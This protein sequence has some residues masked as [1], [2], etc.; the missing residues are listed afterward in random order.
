MTKRGVQN[1]PPPPDGEKSRVTSYELPVTPKGGAQRAGM[2]INQS[3][4][5]VLTPDNYHRGH[6]RLYNSSCF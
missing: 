2:A 5:D 1:H 3:V 6:N 4:L